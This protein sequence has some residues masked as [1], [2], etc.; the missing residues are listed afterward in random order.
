MCLSILSFLTTFVLVYVGFFAFN[1]FLDVTGYVL[2]YP[3]FST[4]FVLVYVGLL[5]SDSLFLS[6]SRL[7]DSVFWLLQV[8]ASGFWFTLTS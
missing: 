2:V 4:T 7:Q 6:G 8:L 3:V 1:F 5:P